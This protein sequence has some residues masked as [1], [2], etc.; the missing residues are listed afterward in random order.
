MFS[1]RALLLPVLFA[2]T[3]GLLLAEPAPVATRATSDYVPP[4]LAQLT[5]PA[6]SELR[7]L[8]ERFTTDREEAKMKEIAPILPFAEE[9]AGLQELRRMMEPVNPAAA[10]STLEKV[11]KEVA[12]AKAGLEAGL[13]EGKGEAAKPGTEA[14]APIVTTRIAAYRAANRLAELR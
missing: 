7:E 12:A 11:R 4:E 9:I 5:K 8:V 2:A 10:A 6:S 14:K 1:P 13:K 3:A